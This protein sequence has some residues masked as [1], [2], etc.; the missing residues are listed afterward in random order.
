MYIWG[1][2]DRGEGEGGLKGE[3]E[4]GWKGE[5]RKKGEGKEGQSAYSN[6]QQLTSQ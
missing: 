3:G 2:R 5:R 6:S 4:G 1:K